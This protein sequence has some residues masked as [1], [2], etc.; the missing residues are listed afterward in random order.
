LAIRLLK[1]P[2]SDCRSGLEDPVDDNPV[3]SHNLE[4]QVDDDPVRS[5][6]RKQTTKLREDS[7]VNVDDYEKEV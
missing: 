6:N 1:I 7:N 5:Q 2:A 3:G 4:D